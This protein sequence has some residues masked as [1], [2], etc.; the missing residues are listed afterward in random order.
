MLLVQQ[1]VEASEGF[2]L[3]EVST[4]VVHALDE[5]RA[6]I[7][8]DRV[9]GRGV[10]HPLGEHLAPLLGGPVVVIDADDSELV[11]KFFGANQ[12]AEGRH[13]EAPGQVAAGA[14]NHHGGR[15]ELSAGTVLCCGR[16]GSPRFWRGRA[17]LALR[18]LA[19]VLR[20]GGARFCDVLI[21]SATRTRPFV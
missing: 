9:A 3:G 8:L 17:R 5:P 21:I 18:R 20:Y 16:G 11:G 2:R 1:R 15:R 7:L 13:D 6:D 14:K 12:V 4:H 19:N 10:P